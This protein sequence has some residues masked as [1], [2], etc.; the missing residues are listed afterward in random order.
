MQRFAV[1]LIGL[2]VFGLTAFGQI[3][4]GT[5]RGRVIDPAGAVVVGANVK[6]VGADAAERSAQTNQAGEFSFNLSPGKY[7]VR[8]AGTGF[9]LY[10][11]AE[12]EVAANRSASLEIALTLE[13]TQA[14]VTVGEE[15]AV[16]ANPEANA[17]ALV[18]REQDIEALPDND[19]DLE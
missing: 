10:E 8:I 11:N 9:A 16:D 14:E 2:F 7:T 6:A 4:N 15:A 12:V 3:G 1:L 17:G 19:D 18:L 5:L 13:Q